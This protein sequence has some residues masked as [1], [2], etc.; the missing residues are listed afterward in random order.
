[1][2]QPEAEPVRQDAGEGE[3]EGDG[4]GEA[5]GEGEG[6]AEDGDDVVRDRKP[7]LEPHADDRFFVFPTD[8]E[9]K[10]QLDHDAIC[11]RVEGYAKR[12]DAQKAESLPQRNKA[13]VDDASI[14]AATAHAAAS[15]SSAPPAT[16]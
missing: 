5:L 2:G 15:T 1:M 9:R 13:V 6:P 4:E 7:A 16:W 10:L 14:T 11:L 3:G 8:D 12:T